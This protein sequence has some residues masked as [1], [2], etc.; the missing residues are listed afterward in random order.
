MAVGITCEENKRPCLMACYCSTITTLH[1][2]W[3]RIGRSDD[4]K[5]KLMPRLGSL[6]LRSWKGKFVCAVHKNETCKYSGR[7]WKLG[8][9]VS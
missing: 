1:S 6:C 5:L 8:S 3:D 2:I 4:P 9:C 7:L